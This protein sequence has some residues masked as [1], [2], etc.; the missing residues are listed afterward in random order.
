MAVSVEQEILDAVRSGC[1][2]A[3]QDAKVHRSKR[4]SVYA[5]VD[6]F[7]DVATFLR[8]KMGFDH[9]MTV[10]C[11]DYLARKE[12]EVLYVIWSTT[13]KVLCSLRTAIPRENP[14]LKTLIGIWEGALYHER[15]VHEMFGVNFEGHP[16]LSLLLLPEGWDKMPPLR[17]DFT[18]TPPQ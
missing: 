17:K 2:D 11:V 10:A 7:V 13:K 5:K 9:F 3:V 16:N 18:P 12:M 14:T 1:P 8:D 6:R 4:I 15:E